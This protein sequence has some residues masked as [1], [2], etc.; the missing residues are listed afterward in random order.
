MSVKELH[1]AVKDNNVDAV[2]TI[3]TSGKWTSG[4]DDTTCID[5]QFSTACELGNTEIIQLF[6]DNVPNLN[7]FSGK[8]YSRLQSAAR[9]PNSNKVVRQLLKA[10]AVANVEDLSTAVFYD[11][12][13]VVKTFLTVGG[14]SANAIEEQGFR[15]FARACKLGDVAMVQLFIDH[16]AI[17]KR[18]K[19][20][21]GSPLVWATYQPRND[22]V[23]HLLIKNGVD[24]VFERSLPTRDGTCDSNY[25]ILLRHGAKTGHLPV[26]DQT[27]L[28]PLINKAKSALLLSALASA[29]LSK[30]KASPAHMLPSDLFRPLGSFLGLSQ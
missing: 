25:L 16:G 19:T 18:L 15:V 27:Y 13:E 2:A 22:K 3:L 9:R 1:R 7:Y 21:R 6:I 24:I 28:V 17:V 8:P 26:E 30:N 5:H 14:V 20:D 4:N 29:K 23:I 12:I 10:G 11:N